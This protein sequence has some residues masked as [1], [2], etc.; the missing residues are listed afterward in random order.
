MSRKSGTGTY[1]TGAAAA[2]AAAAF[3]AIKEKRSGNESSLSD[4]GGE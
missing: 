4:S 1:T 3:G 2:A